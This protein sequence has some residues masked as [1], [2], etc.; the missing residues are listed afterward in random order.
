MNT[1][2]VPEEVP[3]LPSGLPASLDDILITDRLSA[4]PH[5]LPRA[6]S[7]NKALRALATVMA[8]SPEELP[9]TL[10]SFAL[11]LCNADTAGLSL[12]ETTSTGETIFR[13]TNLAGALKGHVGGFTPRGFSP[14]G[15]VLDRTTAQLFSHPEHRFQY[16]GAAGVPFVEALVVPLSGDHPLGTI[17]ILSHSA[18]THFDAEDLR[19]MT[20]LAEFTSSALSM[21]QLLNSEK[22]ARQE[23]ESQLAKRVEVETILRESEEFNRRILESSSD[24]VKVLDLD[25]RVKYMSPVAMKLM[26]VD[27]FSQCDEANWVEF[28]QSADRAIVLKALDEATAGETGNFRAYCATLKGTPKWWDVTITPI[29]DGDGKVVKLLSTSRDVTERKHS[30]EALAKAHDHLEQQVRDRTAELEEQIAE[31]NRAESTLRELT[32]RLLR[33]RDDEQRR[34]ARELH[35]SVGQI[36]AAISMNI[37]VVTAEKGLSPQA[38]KAVSQNTDLI[39]QISTEIRTISH[40]LHPPLLD[41]VGL[42][43]GV[44][45]YLEQFAERSNMKVEL[46]LAEDFGRLPSEL[47]TALFR[48]VQESLTNV[49]RHSESSTAKVRVVRASDE[50]ELEVSDQGKGIPQAKIWEIEMGGASG[51]GLSGMRERVR[52]LGGKFE[53]RSN[54]KG[55]V[56]SVRLPLEKISPG[57]QRQA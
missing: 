11:E 44:R 2:P 31:R 1:S 6:A 36:L 35:D 10:L 20:S 16:F 32:G 38:R 43:S 26:E 40:L 18:S 8:N 52:Q 17:W 34:L 24:C 46:E 25:F 33:L 19:I 29:R 41:E 22:R 23:A 49:H 28:W 55:T 45:W 3:R 57:I 30:D 9:D 7:E 21:I 51:V 15:V 47:E 37:A 12:L 4:R 50:I 42:A 5:R 14:C 27:T 39:G 56:V 53:I 48:L 54:G 13:W